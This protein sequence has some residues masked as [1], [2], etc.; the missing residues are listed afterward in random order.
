[1]QITAKPLV[2]HRIV[3][4]RSVSQAVDLSRKLQN[5][6]ATTIQIPTIQIEPP[7]DTAQIDESI[8][9]LNKFDWIVFTS[10]NGVAFYLKRMAALQTPISAFRDVR[11]AA[12]GSATSTSLEHAGRMPDYVPSEFLSERI[13]IGLGNL[14]GKHVLLPRAD[15]ASEKL[16]DLLRQSGAL[17]T[18]IIAYK[19]AAP[20]LHSD[21][22]RKA[23]QEADIATFTSPS[24][25]RNLV[26]ALGSEEAKKLFT[27]V[28]VACIGPVTF[29]TA[30]ELGIDVKIVASPHTIDALVEAIVHDVSS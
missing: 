25:V 13:V 11:I 14:Q 7:T 20:K 12:I 18:E 8:R 16:P 27:N 2:G 4:T 29:E 28:T 24:T 9:N 10:V 19:T 5:L 22:L 26:A 23:M 3:V 17:V 1:M 30:R 6:G 15:I 21:H